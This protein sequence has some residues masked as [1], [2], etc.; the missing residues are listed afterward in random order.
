VAPRFTG[1]RVQSPIA[2]SF[3]SPAFSRFHVLRRP[4]LVSRC[5]VAIEALPWAVP[6]ALPL[7]PQLLCS[8]KTALDRPSP[9]GAP[10]HGAA[11]LLSVIFVPPTYPLGDFFP[12]KKKFPQMSERLTQWRQ[13]PSPSGSFRLAYSAVR[14]LGGPRTWF[15][16]FFFFKTHPPPGEHAGHPALASRPAGTPCWR[17][18][19]GLP[20]SSPDCLFYSHGFPRSSLAVPIVSLGLGFGLEVLRGLPPPLAFLSGELPAGFRVHLVRRLLAIFF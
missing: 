4:D 19:P 3:L 13:A 10:A 1:R 7:S 17:A 12:Q 6:T 8:C 15:P 16:F 9:P 2:P 20:W 5:T 11:G 14:L 18:A